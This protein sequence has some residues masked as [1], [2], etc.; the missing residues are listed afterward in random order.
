DLDGFKRYN[1]LHGHRKG[2]E[3]LRD[4]ANLVLSSVRSGVDTCYRYGGDEF[5]IMMPETGGENARVVAERIRGQLAARFEGV[6]TAS[7]GIAESALYL[8]V[9]RLLERA[10]RAMYQ[11]KSMGGNRTLLVE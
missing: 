10:D 5:V 7:I 2:D 4:A 8:D 9:E 6:V 11:A 3:L 1:D